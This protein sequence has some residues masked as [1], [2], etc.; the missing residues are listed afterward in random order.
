MLI[1]SAAA[2]ILCKKNTQALVAAGKET[3]LQINADKTKYMVMYQDQIAGQS[4]NIKID[5][6]SLERVE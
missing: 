6:K 2:Y 5:D 4:H 3:G 1:Y